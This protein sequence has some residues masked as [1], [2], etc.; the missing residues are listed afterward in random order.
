MTANLPLETVSERDIVLIRKVLMSFLEQ[1][2]NAALVISKRVLYAC[3]HCNVPMRSSRFRKHV[4]GCPQ[5]PEMLP[6]AVPTF[7]ERV[8]GGK[9]VIVNELRTSAMGLREPSYRSTNGPNLSETR[10]DNSDVNHKS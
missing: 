9:R 6:N 2:E 4:G 10:A 8:L 1:S 5:R 7:N 3:P